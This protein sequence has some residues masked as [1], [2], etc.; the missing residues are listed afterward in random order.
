MRRILLPEYTRF[1]KKF[2]HK[3]NI[4]KL[5]NNRN[6][7]QT[8]FRPSYELTWNRNTELNKLRSIRFNAYK[9]YGLLRKN[10]INTSRG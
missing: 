7:Y 6:T 5:L 8:E 10:K 1:I 3:I 9:N 2:T 4:F